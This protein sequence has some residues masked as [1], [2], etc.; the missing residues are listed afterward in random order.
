MERKVQ[1]LIDESARLSLTKNFVKSLETAKEAKNCEREL[2]RFIEIQGL[3][4]Q[5]V[6][7][8]PFA[9]SLNLA[10]S[11]QE[12]E[13]FDDAIDIYTTMI[14]EKEHP[15]AERLR[16]NIGNILYQQGKYRDAI[17]MYRMVLDQIPSTEREIGFKISLNVG[18][19]FLKM[20]QY[21]EAIQHFEAIMASSPSH[22]VG[23][24]LVLCYF[25]ICDKER[26]R[27]GFSKLSSI[28]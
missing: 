8:L 4:E 19:A 25:T 3:H 14:K 13:M 10:I 22:E 18:K 20:G 21:Q 1:H 2:F 17:K 5:T 23:F 7:D 27:R 28:P 15:N 9:S 12:S 16:V 6:N 26:I 11:F 24:N